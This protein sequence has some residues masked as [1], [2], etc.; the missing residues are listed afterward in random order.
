MIEHRK[1]ICDLDLPEGDILSIED[2]LRQSMKKVL[3]D[4]KLGVGKGK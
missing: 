1:G 3:E 2:A 4:A